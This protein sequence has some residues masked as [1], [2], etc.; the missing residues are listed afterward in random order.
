MNSSSPSFLRRWTISLSLLLLGGITMIL[1]AQPQTA[2]V[3]I[4]TVQDS[5][6]VLADDVPLGISPLQV[7]VPC[8]K[9]MHLLFNK[10]GFLPRSTSFEPKDCSDT[11]ILVGLNRPASISITSQPESALVYVNNRPAGVTPVTL[12]D[13]PPDTLRIALRKNYH[14]TWFARLVPVE[15]HITSLHIPLESYRSTLNVFS[16]LSDASVFI[17]D[18]LVSVG[19]ITN[20]DVK[21]GPH[22][23]R[24]EHTSTGRLL[25]EQFF[26][27][28]AQV[29]AFR[30][31]FGV[32]SLSRAGL[33]FVL[34]GS[35][36]I[37]DGAYT[38]GIIMLFGGVALGLNAIGTQNAYTDRLSRYDYAWNN[39]INAPT[40]IEAARRHQELDSRKTDLN[41]YYARRNVS[42]GMFLAAY[43]YSVVDA[44]LG[45]L[46]V[47]R[48]E[49]LPLTA[50]QTNPGS[51]ASLSAVGAQ[52]RI[53]LR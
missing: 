41:T 5:V 18:S 50:S 8:D 39:Y 27:Q 23:L 51:S 45:H 17:D 2:R 31:D 19:S 42:L 44:L 30:A 48:I 20:L 43:T 6:T 53:A 37:L 13:L 28:V 35:A 7:I 14:T 52:V 3:H 11:T 47:D 40:E 32:K 9:T 29:L 12:S 22:R 10:M 34:P 15:G 26:V 16:S 25:D 1:D 46:V 36:Q 21:S 24:V 4:I 49:V 33:A 38:E